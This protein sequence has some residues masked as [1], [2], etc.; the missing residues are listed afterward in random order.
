MENFTESTTADAID[1]KID[2]TKDRFS[3]LIRWEANTLK[4]SIPIAAGAC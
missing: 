3:G 4:W 2:G 1:L